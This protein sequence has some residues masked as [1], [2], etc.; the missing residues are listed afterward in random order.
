MAPEE[1]Y[2][3]KKLSTLAD[4][5]STEHRAAV[6]DPDIEQMKERFFLD[7][8]ITLD[9]GIIG[10]CRVDGPKYKLHAAERLGTVKKYREIEPGNG[11]WRIYNAYRDAGLNTYADVKSQSVE[12][13]QI[14]NFIVKGDFKSAFY[15]PNQTV[16]ARYRIAYDGDMN[17][18]EWFDDSAVDTSDI[19][20]AGSEFSLSFKLT[21]VIFTR[22]G[23]NSKIQ[24]QLY[25]TNEEGRYY[26]PA[27][28]LSPVTLIVLQLRTQS[29][30]NGVVVTYY[31]NNLYFYTVNDTASPATVTRLYKSATGLP[32]S[33]V[34]E[35]GTFYDVEN[36][37]LSFVFGTDT[38]GGEPATNYLLEVVNDTPSPVI[39]IPIT[40][41][42]FGNTANLACR[43]ATTSTADVT[44]F[45]RT[46]NDNPNDPDNGKHYKDGLGMELADS[47][48]YI[49]DDGVNYRIGQLIN[50]VFT[51]TGNN[52]EV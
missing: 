33:Y 14:D 13:N 40:F 20:A 9:G 25:A 19:A 2:I 52:C 12:V 3:E 10:L 37:Y 7:D 49:D 38:V 4:G 34:P 27:M 46:N 45:I 24:F 47:G 39:F 28:G 48:Y 43:K 11:E 22:V 36:P 44:L 32:N 26:F 5:V 1:A 51:F 50:G 15:N 21:S 42:S 30:P 18:G 17:Y 23:F 6:V 16:G 41:K 29:S 8:V 31:V 35:S